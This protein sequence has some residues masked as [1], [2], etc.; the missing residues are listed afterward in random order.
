MAERAVLKKNLEIVSNNYIYSD[1]VNINPVS[2]IDAEIILEIN[3]ILKKLGANEDLLSIINN[4]KALSDEN[5]LDN[6]M[7][8]N[9]SFNG[10]KGDSLVF[11]SLSNFIFNVNCIYS[12]TKSVSYINNK[13][14][15]CIIINES[16]N[17]KIAYANKQIMFNTQ[18]KRD[19]ELEEFKNKMRN[20]SKIIFL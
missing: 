10:E 3:D 16:N 15:Y 20:N 1:N 19:S 11:I 8:F 9:A 2:K 6:L 5:I 4:Y 18:E 13:I 12:I 7:K 14:S 17:E